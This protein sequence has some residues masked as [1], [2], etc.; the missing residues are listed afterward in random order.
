MVRVVIWYEKSVLLSGRI[1]SRSGPVVYWYDIAGPCSSSGD[2][3]VG[4]SLFDTIRRNGQFS[5]STA[6]MARAQLP[7]GVFNLNLANFSRIT[8]RN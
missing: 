4:S 2:R 7:S 6:G 1:G 5:D 8:F 3:L